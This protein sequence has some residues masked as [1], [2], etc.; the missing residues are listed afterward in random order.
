MFVLGNYVNNITVCICQV[1]SIVNSRNSLNKYWINMHTWSGWLYSVHNDIRLKTVRKFWKLELILKGRQYA[2]EHC[3]FYS[4]TLFAHYLPER[5]E[6]QWEAAVELYE[7]NVY[8]GRFASLETSVTFCSDRP[9]RLRWRV[10]HKKGIIAR[11][12]KVQ[13]QNT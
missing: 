1:F 12:F 2:G 5:M 4:Y 13:I 8:R 7:R 11:V 6:E 9:K 10:S 3:V